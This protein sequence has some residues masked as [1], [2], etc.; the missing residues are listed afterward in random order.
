MVEDILYFMIIVHETPKKQ[1]VGVGYRR[2][3]E[4]GILENYAKQPYKKLKNH[5]NKKES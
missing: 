5:N 3:K 4:V 1:V 2:E